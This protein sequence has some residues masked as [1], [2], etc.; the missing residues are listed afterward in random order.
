MSTLMKPVPR[1]FRPGL[2]DRLEAIH[3]AMPPS[4]S[5]REGISLLVRYFL[6]QFA[7][8]LLRKGRLELT[9]KAM[10]CLERYDWSGHVRELAHEVKWLVVLARDL[11]VTEAELS[12]EVRKDN[13]ATVPMS[14]AL[15]TGLSLKAAV[16]ELEQQMLQQALVASGYHKMRA[17]KSEGLSRQGLIKKL[18]R[19][20]I[21]FRTGTT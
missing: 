2:A 14:S 20:G 17:A 9:P 12:A 1:N 3:I 11:L 6:D 5:V 10:H 19:Y 8:E 4:R 18:K 15:L 13:R 16:E 21:T 7:R